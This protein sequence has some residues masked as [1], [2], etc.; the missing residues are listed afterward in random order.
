M[1]PTDLHKGDSIVLSG[2]INQSIQGW[3]I[4]CELWDAD[5]HY[6]RKATANVIGGSEQ[7]I[8]IVDA[9]AG[10]FKIYVQPIETIQF[11]GNVN[12]QIKVKDNFDQETT[13]QRDYLTITDGR[14]TWEELSNLTFRVNPVLSLSTE[15]NEVSV[16]EGVGTSHTF[17]TIA[18]YALPVNGEE[19][20]LDWVVSDIT[21]DISLNSP[22]VT[23][24][25][26]AWIE[27]AI[28]VSSNLSVLS[29]EILP[30]TDV[31]IDLRI[32]LTSNINSVIV[33]T[34]ALHDDPSI[35]MSMSVPDPTVVEGAGA[36]IEGYEVRLN[37]RVYS[38][39]FG[40]PYGSVLY[41]STLA[42][43]INIYDA[44]VITA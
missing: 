12:I 4:R 20:K 18:M 21:T 2:K 11:T 33:T 41:P 25:S 3:E 24:L 32:N 38:P 17:N 22:E 34:G 31:A 27:P 1:I 23:I 16:V 29:P 19:I 6:V 8:E 44:T 35:S 15:L 9:S 13:I 30:H 40:I 37:T 10:R 43:T 36:L 26:N 5:N 42:S 28:T 14:I 7:Q 39:Y